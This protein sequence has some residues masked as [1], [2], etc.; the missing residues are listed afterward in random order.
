MFRKLIVALFISIPVIPAVAL[1]ENFMFAG[2][3]FAPMPFPMMMVIKHANLTKEQ[4]ARVH[5]IIGSSFQQA[6][7]LMKQLHAIHDQIADKLM[8]TGTVTASD[9]EPL[10]KEESDLHQRIDQQML[11]AAL[12]IRGLLTPDQLARAAHVH[13]QLKSLRQQMDALVGENGPPMGPPP[14]F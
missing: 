10:Q 3:V 14:G 6:Q 13:E 4:Q 5:Q 9:I 7:P 12:Q 11:S 8:S 1:A 2:P